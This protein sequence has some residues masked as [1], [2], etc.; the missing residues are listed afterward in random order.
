[1]KKWK[2][3]SCGNLTDYIHCKIDGDCVVNT[4]GESELIEWESGKA[5]C[6]KCGFTEHPFRQGVFEIVEI[7][8]NK[9]D[10]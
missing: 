5:I 10:K 1:M 6:E 9:E 3:P 8:A 2:C 7:E 4:N